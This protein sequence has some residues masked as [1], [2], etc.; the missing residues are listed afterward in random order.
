[1]RGD[2]EQRLIIVGGGAAG[3]F[4]AIAAKIHFPRESVTILE[5]GREVLRKVRLS[6]GGRC[7]VTHACFNIQDLVKNYPRGQDFL[8]RAFAYFQPRDTIRWFHE[9]GVPLTK[10]EDG[11]V[12]PCSNTSDSVVSCLQKK[13]HVLGVHCLVH[14]GVRCIKKLGGHFVI[15]TTDTEFAA[16]RVILATGSSPGGLSFA[17]QLGHNIITGVPSLFTFTIAPF[18]FEQLSG[19][20]VPQVEIRLDGFSYT[21]TGALLITHWGFSGPAVL[22]LSAFGAVFLAK[23]QYKARVFINWIPGLLERDFIRFVNK[24]KKNH[25]KRS[26]GNIYFPFLPRRLWHALCVQG[27][28]ELHQKIHELDSERTLYLYKSLSQS[29]HL[30]VGKSQYK[31]EFVQAGGVDTGEVGEGMESLICKNLFFSGEILN[32]DGITGGFNFQNAWTTGWLAGS[33][34]GVMKGM[35]PDVLG[36]KHCLH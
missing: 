11:R 35:Q 8:L 1:M 32:V 19:V 2:K 33:M 6:G 27:G 22:K 34:R 31:D 9:Q 13:A 26:L 23:R 18:C 25:A 36:A 4:A 10:E 30:M 17:K 29:V 24:E 15:T 3:F 28:F 20:A 21:S 14:Q 16:E 7:N 12:F 5:S